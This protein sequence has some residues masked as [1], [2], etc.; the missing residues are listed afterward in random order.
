[1]SLSIAKQVDGQAA[2]KAKEEFE[3]VQTRPEL[4]KAYR[5]RG[6][7]TF[8]LVDQGELTQP[9]LTQPSTGSGRCARAARGRICILR[10]GARALGSNSEPRHGDSLGYSA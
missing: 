9:E 10:S 4:D 7:A 5:E 1:M 2:G 6:K 8:E 3:D